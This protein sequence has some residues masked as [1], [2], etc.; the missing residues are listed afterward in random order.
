MDELIG[1]ACNA[2][3][4]SQ[5]FADTQNIIDINRIHKIIRHSFM[6]HGKPF[7]SF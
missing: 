3:K 2:S 5:A 1:S 6:D 7:V 4:K